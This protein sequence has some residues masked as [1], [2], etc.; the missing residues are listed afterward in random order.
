MAVCNIGTYHIV[1][2]ERFKKYPPLV[3][4][5]LKGEQ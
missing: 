5:L 4:A 3:M 1:D 2:L